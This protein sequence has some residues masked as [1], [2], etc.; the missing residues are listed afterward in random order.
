MA[1][2]KERSQEETDLLERSNKKVKTGDNGGGA[3]PTDTVMASRVEETQRGEGGGQSPKTSFRDKLM[4]RMGAG[5]LS[6]EEEYDD[7]VSDDEEEAMEEEEETDCPVIRV[8]KKEKRRLRSP[9]RQTLI[10]KILGRSIGYNF[11][12]RKINNLWRPKAFMELVAIGNDYFLVKFA[13]KDDYDYA[14]FEGPWMIMDHYLTVREW[15]PNFDPDQDSMERLL[16]WVRIPC[17]PIEY[18]DYDFLMRVGEKIGK[19]VKIDDATDSVS[20]GKFARL[21]VE[22][23]LTKPLLAKFKLR[24]RVRRIEYEGIHLVCFKCGCYGHRQDTCLLATGPEVEAHDQRPDKE[25]DNVHP[26]R[27]AVVIV[28][29][30]VTDDYGPWMLAKSR[31]RRVI[32]KQDGNPIKGEDRDVRKGNKSGNLQIWVDDNPRQSRFAVLEL[33]E[34]QEARMVAVDGFGNNGQEVPMVGR[35]E[36]RIT[37]GSGRGRRPNVWV[38]KAAVTDPIGPPTRTNLIVTEGPG[39]GPIDPQSSTSANRHRRAAAEESHVVVRGFQSGQQIVRSVVMNE[40][41]SKSDA[42]DSYRVPLSNLEH[43]QDPPVMLIN[44]PILEGDFMEVGE[45]ANLDEDVAIMAVRDGEKCLGSSMESKGV[46]GDACAASREFSRALKDLLRVHKPGILGLLETRV[47]GCHA[48][49]LCKQWCFDNWVRVEAAGFSGG[50]WVFWRDYY[51]VEVIKTH[52]QFLHLSVKNGNSHPWLLSVVYGS[53]DSSLRKLLWRDLNKEVLEIRGSWIVVG[54]FNSVISRDEVSSTN[55]TTMN[56][57]SGFADWIFDQEL[58]DMGFSG[59]IYT[60]TRGVKSDT[61]KGARLD[62]ALC[63]GSWRERFENASV[64]HLPKLYSDHSPVLIRFNQNSNVR[65]SS[66]F[67]FQAAWLTHPGLSMV[68]KDNWHEGESFLE[69]NVR[70]AAALH[71]WNQTNFGSIFKRK[72]RLWARI[73]GVQSRLA[74]SFSTRLHRLELKLRKELDMV[75]YQEELLWYQKSREEWIKSGDRNTKFYHAS[76]II[77]RS[78]SKVES[79]RDMGDNSIWVSDPMEIQQM[80]NCYFQSLFTADGSCDISLAARNSFP[81]LNP[82]HREIIA[83]SFRHEDIKQAL[84]DMAPF[85][86]PGPDGFHAGFYQRM[87]D[88]I[89]MDLCCLAMQFFETGHLPQGINDTLLVLIPKVPMPEL[90]SQFRPISLCN[91]GYKVITKTM[92]NRLKRILPH[93]VAP[94]QSSFVPGRQITDNIIIY[95]EVLHSMRRKKTGQGYMAIKIDLEKAYDRLSWEFIQDTLQEIGFTDAW[96]RN[97]MSCVSTSR[98]SIV[99]NGQQLDWFKPSRGVRQGDAISP[100]LFVLCV[101]RLGHLIN[102][103]VLSGAWKAIKLSPY[104]PA[105]SHL[106]FADDMVLFAEASVDQIKV[107]ME[108]LNFF[109]ASSGQR[110]SFQKSS[111]YVSKNVDQGVASDIS[112]LSGIPLTDNLGKYLGT[113]SIHGRVS[114]KE[115]QY[116]VDRISSRLEGWKTRH[117]SFAGRITLAKSVLT[118]IPIYVMQ[119]ALLP[120][121]TCLHI[122]RLVRRFLWGGSE[123]KRPVSLVSWEQVTRPIEMGG[124]GIR[125]LE[126]TNHAFMAKVGWRLLNEKQNLWAKVVSSKYMRG[127]PSVVNLKGK[128]GSSNLWRGIVKAGNILHKG[129]KALVRNGRR[130]RFWLDHW[131]GDSPLIDVCLHDI[132]LVEKHKMISCYWQRGLG[133]IWAKFHHLLPENIVQQLTAFM[134]REEDDMED[135]ICWG[136]SNNGKFS[137][138]SAYMATVGLGGLN[139]D[140]LWPKIWRL[141]VPQ[142]VTVFIWQL[143]HQR[144]MCNSERFK[145]RFTGDPSC[146]LCSGVDEDVNHIFR[147]CPRAKQFWQAILPDQELSFQADLGFNDWLHYNICG[148]DAR[149]LSSNWAAMFAVILWCL[150]KWRNEY[151][152]NDKVLSLAVK[153]EWFQLHMAEIE[154]AFANQLQL[155]GISVNKRVMLEFVGWSPPPDGWVKLNTDGCCKGMTGLAVGGGLVRDVR[156][157]WLIGFSINIGIC[158]A[159][160]AELWAVFEGLSLAWQNGFRKVFLETDSLVVASWLQ[161]GCVPNIPI[162]NLIYKCCDLLKKDWEVNIC[163]VL[164]EGNRC[165]D[166]LA[167]LALKHDRGVLVLHQPPVDIIEMLREDVIGVSWPIRVVRNAE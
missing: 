33:E 111:I 129:V 100:Y 2:E 20:R 115:Y 65:Q 128:Q 16:V 133:W 93:V 77:K 6:H 125:K 161:D 38:S 159:V 108:C 131:M 96:V 136:L 110:V 88:V 154:R 117:L 121:E 8:S 165:A 30:E 157:R 56:R 63:N 132:S 95:Q 4:G 36:K 35:D 21:C 40:A 94:N 164:R 97:I 29:P 74:V 90:V 80:V 150:W 140:P 85:K 55:R 57:C 148:R 160:E 15:F 13:S 47:S 1:I 14:K 58:I 48:D 23:D 134:V 54:D 11:L 72:K 37:L 26:V 68:V 151:V 152:F 142:R 9:W 59:P 166:L 102:N 98:M 24:R 145:R 155:N 84:F 116:V 146:K 25:D 45:E 50:I 123:D 127:N 49:Q 149:N 44:S 130:T 64:V 104:G 17:L 61:F 82:E 139:V 144:I 3:D 60:W 118:T 162:S 71:W 167:N 89:G 124:L 43:H 27:K 22:V 69:N 78:R 158:S 79:L 67:K 51:Q 18:Y 41:K 39:R 156:G 73:G 135:G 70:I 137:V 147:R 109:C 163:H 143:T 46:N 75:L 34:N 112:R 83:A 52:P 101:E 76:T 122:E 19:P 141:N 103:A 138:K 119:T 42:A 7:S 87:W 120:K 105:L 99:W 28:N 153:V 66:S 31:S 10:I 62:R 92:T 113:P 114:S 12:L 107:V 81:E 86:A 5:N 126:Q 106:F 91:V 53:P 32:R